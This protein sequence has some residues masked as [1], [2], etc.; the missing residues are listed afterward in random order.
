MFFLAQRIIDEHQQLIETLSDID[1]LVLACYQF[2]SVL[3]LLNKLWLK[4]MTKEKKRYFAIHE[5][6]D[7]WG[8]SMLQ[9]RQA[10][11]AI[12]GSFVV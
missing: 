12:S 2:M 9:V 5:T 3:A 7:G 8:C 4:T 11:H 10:F 6:E 1:V